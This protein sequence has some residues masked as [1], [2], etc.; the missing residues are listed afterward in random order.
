MPTTPSRDQRPPSRLS[1]LD[2]DAMLDDAT[3]KQAFVTPMFDVIA[4]RYDRFTR[5][6]SF[7]MDAGWKREGLDALAQWHA[8][9]ARAGDVTVLDVASGTGD[10]AFAA[11]S[12]W[13]AAQVVS[14]DAAL[15]MTRRAQARARSATDSRVVCATADL[16]TLPLATESVSLVTAGYA[17]RNVPDVR[18]AV[19]E[20]ARVLQPGGLLLTLDFYRPESTWWR[21]LFLGYLRTAG[22]AVGWLWHRDPVVYG[23]IAR[24]IAR[25]LSWQAFSALLEAEG[26]IVRDVRRYL[27]GGI[28]RHVAERVDRRVSAPRVS[29]D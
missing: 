29:G 27:G 11:A 24:S 2:V 9:G 23:Y 20:I 8:R 4:P 22:D 28:A 26:F 18:V 12:R 13:P 10:L 3:R 6:F 25:F 1:A 21:A 16:M 19:R 5:W 7:G 15:A 17:L 14:T